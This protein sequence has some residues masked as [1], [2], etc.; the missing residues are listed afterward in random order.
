M[1]PPDQSQITVLDVP[2]VLTESFVAALENQGTG[3]TPL[4]VRLREGPP[5]IENFLNAKAYADRFRAA[6]RRLE[7]REAPF[8]AI[9]EGDLCGF[10]FE[11]ALCCHA[12]FFSDPAIRAWFPLIRY[13]S[14]PVLGTTQRL[15]WLVGPDK[16]V[17]VLLF[18]GGLV[19]ADIGEVLP[20]A[21]SG[22]N[23]MQGAKEWA[24]RNPKP[25]QPWDIGARSAF[26]SQELPVRRLLEKSYLRL[27][28]KFPPEDEVFSSL[29]RCFHDGWER[30]FDAGLK[31]E[32]EEVRRLEKSLVAR[33][34]ERIYCSLRQ[35]AS[36][37]L[38]VVESAVLKLGVLGSG[39]M[40]TGIALTAA[41]AG[42]DVRLFDTS[43]E[44]LTR[45]KQKLLKQTDGPA[46]V[47]RIVFLEKIEGIADADF[48]IEAAFERLGLKKD[49]LKTLSE[50]VGPSTVLASN[51]TTLPISSLAEA[52]P[53]PGR[54]I[55]THF[56]SPVERMEL[57][58]IIMGSATS[59]ETLNRALGLSRVLGKVPIVV[60][61]GPG[62]YTS[63]VVMAYAQEAFFLVHEG[64]SP[65]LIDNVARNAGMPIGPL[66]MADVLSLDLHLDIARSL[67]AHGRGSARYAGQTV[68]IL[69][70]FVG[71]NRLGRKTG[72]GIYDYPENNKPMVWPGLA[73]LFPQRAEPAAPEIIAQRLFVIQ[74]LETLSAL[75]EGIIREPDTA[76]LASVLGW[77]YPAFKGGPMGYIDYLGGDQFERI[78]ANLEKQFG[79]RFDA[80]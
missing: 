32:A 12:R 30:S 65:T 33:N 80:P 58:E 67:A 78:R 20:R 7:Q 66:A 55:G 48:V 22:G 56:F 69:S 74:T 59:E 37:N 68:E 11:L 38:P 79:E 49:I 36:R 26:H 1:L 72:G 27:R 52:C 54:V 2:A 60:R 71:R 14:I 40:G 5:Q 29:L 18:E 53:A 25:R 10:A 31:I 62:F 13:G 73:N 51:T 64:I 19:A 41:R 47:E 4:L 45:S 21:A 70:A 23:P 8:L 6:L 24:H 43:T 50:L 9:V 34:R 3:S 16:T 75:K 28:E 39:L 17:Q 46:V 61:D 63:R 57:V 15:P 77:G 42:C 35:Q 44:A 76:D